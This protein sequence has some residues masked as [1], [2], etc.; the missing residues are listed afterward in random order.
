MGTSVSENRYAFINRDP[1]PNEI[2]VKKE[3]TIKFMFVDLE[4][5]MAFVQT[6]WGSM[7]WGEFPWGENNGIDIGID[8]IIVSVS[9][10]QAL[11]YDVKTGVRTFLNGF[12]G[13]VSL[14]EN[15]AMFAAVVGEISFPVGT[16]LISEQIVSISLKVVSGATTVLQD[17]Y[18]F[19]IED[20]APP[21]IL[22]IEAID[23]FTARIIYDDTMATDGEGSVLDNN[24]FSVI[25]KNVFPF[26]AVNL[27]ILE[28]K[29]VNGMN[30]TGFDIC[31]NWQQTPGCN[32]NI[33]ALDIADEKRNHSADLVA[34]FKGFEP[35]TK[36]GRFFSLWKMMPEINRFE[37]KTQDLIRFCL[38]MQELIDMSLVSIDKFQQRIDIDTAEVEEL[39][40]LDIAL[41]NPFPAMGFDLNTDKRR[42]LL[43]S[44]IYLYGL[45][46]T[47]IG[48]ES[49]ILFLLGIEAK[50]VNYNAIGWILGVD[51]LGEGTHAELAI[52][53]G[54]NGTNLQI[55]TEKKWKVLVDDDTEI[56]I[57][58]ESQIVSDM[59]SVQANEIETIINETGVFNS[60]LANDFTPPLIVGEAIEPFE[61]QAGDDL[62]ITI[63][64]EIFTAVVNDSD[65]A[66][67][68]S[69]TFLE[70]QRF[71]LS[72][73]NNVRAVRIPTDTTNVF[74]VGLE[75][76]ISDNNTFSIQPG[77][78]IATSIGFETEEKKSTMS[79]KVIVRSLLNGNEGSIV[80]LNPESTFVFYGLGL[81][82]NSCKGSGSAILAPS[83]SRARFSFDIETKIVLD[84]A[85]ESKVK[86]IAKYMKPVQTHIVNIGCRTPVADVGWV[87]GVSELAETTTLTEVING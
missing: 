16:I 82:V 47:D 3:T 63:N 6:G 52:D 8:T 35:Q 2:D 34:T 41:A 14:F 79:E 84:S 66:V 38:C 60:Y 15:S 75:L 33:L 24:N 54:E 11:N 61:I 17:D 37:D 44:L 55:F 1:Q 73:F 74:S 10:I 20:Y 23:P 30:S 12:G 65:I 76:T 32:Y 56:E 50:I 45:K 53:T 69:M 51:E 13:S 26:P 25:R 80:T 78:I 40:H 42:Q 67:E 19:I 43:S 83:A 9:N 85:L 59:S 68:S 71:I 5:D 86:M 57:D 70:F 31:F 21:A 29:Q 62:S 49:A 81:R 72:N 87:L 46:G 77:S 28:I 22:S 58:F 4:T 36:P 64:N 7:P 27:E 18:S 48:I 39:D